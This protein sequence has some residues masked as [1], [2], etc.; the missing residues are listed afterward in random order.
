MI[1]TAKW[2]LLLL[3]S[4]NFTTHIFST[5]T[6]KKLQ[7]TQHLDFTAVFLYKLFIRAMH[8][9]H[10]KMIKTH[11]VIIQPSALAQ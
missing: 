4:V 7:S 6:E 5:T 1:A 3:T 10:N 8:C 11:S 2:Q 9:S